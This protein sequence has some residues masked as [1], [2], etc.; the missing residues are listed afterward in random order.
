VKR[1]RCINNM[2][3]NIGTKNEAKVRAVK[4]AFSQYDFLKEAEIIPVSV[5]SGVADQPKS[6]EETVKGAKNRA[7]NAFADCQY[8]FGLESGLVEVP[9]SANG[10]MD[11][12]CCAIYDGKRFHLGLSCAFELPSAIQKMINEGMDITQASN[13]VG[14]SSNPRLGEAEGLIG[15]LT[16]GRIKREEYTKQAVI[17][18]LI[19][20]E[21]PELYAKE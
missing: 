20:L 17:M 21:N 11:L 6:M 10:F 9:G 15:I 2:K 4:S 14:L 7:I 19:Q 12:C 1:R 18:A 13:A 8:S 16:K 3:V 5:L